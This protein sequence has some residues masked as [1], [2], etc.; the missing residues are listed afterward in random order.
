L[1]D[2]PTGRKELDAEGILHSLNSE[3]R[4]RG[5]SY[6]VDIALVRCRVTFHISPDSGIARDENINRIAVTTAWPPDLNTH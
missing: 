4:I 3:A 5:L 1:L 6:G 2:P